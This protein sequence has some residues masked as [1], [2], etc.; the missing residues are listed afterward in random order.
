MACPAATPASGNGSTLSDIGPILDSPL[1]WAVVI[2]V[3]GWPVLLAGGI[4]G[5]VIGWLIARKTR[6][7]LGSIAGLLAGLVLGAIGFFVYGG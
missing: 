1:G 7:W 3:L 6:P 5:L 4:V 2:V